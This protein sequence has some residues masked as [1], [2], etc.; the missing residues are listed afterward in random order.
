M[1]TEN[2]V[3][4]NFFCAPG[5]NRRLG[6]S[7]LRQAFGLNIGQPGEENTSF[8]KSIAGSFAALALGVS[9]ASTPVLAHGEGGFHGGFGGGDFHGGF[10]GGDFHGGFG[11]GGFRGGFG[12]RGLRKGSRDRGFRR[13]FGAYYAYCDYG[14]GYYGYR[15]CLLC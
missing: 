12:D 8:F 15:N 3:V 4:L 7:P 5:I 11:G 1:P 13:G 14:Y 9:F 10:G 6:K 2:T